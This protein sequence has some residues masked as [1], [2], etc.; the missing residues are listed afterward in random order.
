LTVVG[1]ILRSELEV[2]YRACVSYRLSRR[3]EITIY[4]VTL[5]QVKLIF[6]LASPNQILN[7][8]C[9]KS[10]LFFI[11]TTIKKV[12]AE[13]IKAFCKVSTYYDIDRQTRLTKYQVQNILCI[14]Q[15]IPKQADAYIPLLTCTVRAIQWVIKQKYLGTQDHLFGV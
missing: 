1:C 3:Q 15:L 11:Y 14:Y 12:N 2:E 9:G 5:G 10:F 8:K 7:A 13:K 4:T 6:C